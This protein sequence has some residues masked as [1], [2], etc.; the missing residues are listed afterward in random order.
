MTQE[1]SIVYI[2]VLKW[3]QDN[4][5]GID[6]IKKKD[7]IHAHLFHDHSIDISERLLRSILSKLRHEGHVG[8]LSSEPAGYWFIPLHTKDRREINAVLRSIAEE[9]SRALKQLTGL[10]PRKD[11]YLHKLEEADGVQC[12]F[13]QFDE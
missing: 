1:K 10:K 13:K 11:K 7:S 5:Y 2:T 6:N 12:S 3:M 4:C 8:S 9:E